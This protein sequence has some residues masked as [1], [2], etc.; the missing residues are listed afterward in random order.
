MRSRFEPADPAA[1]PDPDVLS[2]LPDADAAGVR[3]VLVNGHLSPELSRLDAGQTG[4]SA[5]SLRDALASRPASL[6]PWLGRLASGAFAELNTR[7]RRR[8]GRAC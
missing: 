3:L 1:R 7:A 8:R 5:M 6:E 4:V 2:L